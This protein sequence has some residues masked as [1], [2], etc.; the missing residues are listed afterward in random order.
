[1]TKPE[2]AHAF[3]RKLFGP[4]QDEPERINNETEAKDAEPKGEDDPTEPEAKP[5]PGDAEQD[6]NA[7]LAQLFRGSP[8]KQEADAAFFRKLHPPTTKEGDE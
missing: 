3:A 2:A 6:H 8:A 5:E 4:Q 7:L 1:M